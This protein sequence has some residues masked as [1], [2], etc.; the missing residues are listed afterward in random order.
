MLHLKVRNGIAS[1]KRNFWALAL[2]AGLLMF[3]QDLR[4]AEDLYQHTDYYGSLKVLQAIKSPDA[5]TY[6]LMGKNYFMAGDLKRATDHFQKAATLDPKHSD[7]ALWLGRAWGRRAETAS[8]FTAP[9][10]ASK[11]RQ[12]F[13]L[14]V[15][16]DPHNGEAT[17]DLFDYY[18]NAPGFLGGGLDKA[19]ELAKLI[20]KNDAAEGHFAAAQLAD[21][22]KQFDTAEEQLRRAVELAPRQVGRVLD[23]ARYLAKHGRVQESEAAFAQAEKIAPD[24]PKVLYTRAKTYVEAK[25]NLDQAKALLRKYLQSNLTPEDPPREEAQKLLRKTACA[26]SCS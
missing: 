21:R 7:Y 22:R 15:Q 24:S 26:N 3:G 10:A 5:K 11:A 9:F 8:P 14:A 2:S 25:R 4:N 23:L 18:L 20:E 19:A 12:Y 13:E 1:M 17:G 16:L 6:C